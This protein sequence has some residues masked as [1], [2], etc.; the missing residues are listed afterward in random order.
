MKEASMIDAFDTADFNPEL[1]LSS[2]FLDHGL[3]FVT[4]IDDLGDNII[5]AD[6]LQQLG[7]SVFYTET[8]IATNINNSA[9]AGLCATVVTQQHAQNPLQQLP[10]QQI[11]SQPPSA[12][13]S[14]RARMTI[15]GK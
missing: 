3:D 9:N 14:T 1:I 2:V 7:S 15:E 12:L 13:L 8:P 6:L 10:Q 4:N 11:I 5:A